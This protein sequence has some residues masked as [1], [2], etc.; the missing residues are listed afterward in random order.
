MPPL[1][2]TDLVGAIGAFVAEVALVAAFQNSLL[3]LPIAVMCHLIVAT[4]LLGRYMLR[5]RRKRDGS[6]SLLLAFVVLV[7]GP[8]GAL[9]G[10]FI[11]WLSRPERSDVERLSQWYARIALSTDVSAGT[12]RSDRI[13]TGR[14]ANLNA[15][16]PH[17]FSGVLEH[18]NVHDKQM[19]LGLIAR[20]F[21]ADY[22]PALKLALVSEEPVIRVQA[23]AVAAKIRGSLA[24]RAEAAL[25]AAADP[26][27]PV[28][29]ALAHV[30]E[31]EK[32]A[33]SGLMEE[34]DKLRAE[35][36]IDG[37]LASAVSRLDRTRSAHTSAAHTT[38]RY[39]ARLLADMRFADLRR[40][41]R[42]RAWRAKHGLRFRPVARRKTPI[43]SIT[44]ATPRPEASG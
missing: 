19:V 23:A 38:E 36:L 7:A 14:I 25:T 33:A 39:E 32:Y 30:A 24:A 8:F 13:A 26:T 37:L 42:A 43:R 6:A 44:A 16:M 2:S 21:H 10:L 34:P 20:R 9:G 17:S 35:T 22:L 11:G 41:R 28:D 15:A 40:L 5:V 3:P 29:A 4:V 27:T 12:R 31:A 1:R 18:G